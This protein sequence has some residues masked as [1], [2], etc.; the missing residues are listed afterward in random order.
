MRVVDFIV[1]YSEAVKQAKD[2]AQK[3]NNKQFSPK[4][5]NK[6]VRKR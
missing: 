1:E 5:R 3:R 2:E 6:N 4:V